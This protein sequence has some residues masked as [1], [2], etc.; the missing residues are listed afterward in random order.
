[1]NILNG[2]MNEIFEVTHQ[3]KNNF[4]DFSI[5]FSIEIARSLAPYTLLAFYLIR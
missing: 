4:D 3:G 2:N 5:I 1:M